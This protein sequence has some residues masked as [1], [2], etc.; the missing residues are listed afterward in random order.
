MPLWLLLVLL[1]Y[2]FFNT[3]YV[4]W[5]TENK[6]CI[7]YVQ[8]SIMTVGMTVVQIACSLMAV[9]FIGKKAEMKMLFM[10]IPAILTST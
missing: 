5:M 9:L 4:S 3:A 10:L 1:A 7:N 2:A 8:V 6:L